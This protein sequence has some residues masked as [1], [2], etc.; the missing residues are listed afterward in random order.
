MNF[1]Q[2]IPYTPEYKL[3]NSMTFI[4]HIFS[5]KPF[6]IERYADYKNF[7]NKVMNKSFTSRMECIDMANKISPGLGMT[8]SIGTIETVLGLQ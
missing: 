2:Y 1:V 3:N 7:K 8:E 5:T 6:T 4:K